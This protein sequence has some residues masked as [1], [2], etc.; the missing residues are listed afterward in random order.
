MKCKQCGK[1]FR[2]VIRKYGELKGK[3]EWL[4]DDVCFVEIN[5]HREETGHTFE[6]IKEGK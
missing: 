3:Q 6:E 5:S 1:V 2:K 4:T